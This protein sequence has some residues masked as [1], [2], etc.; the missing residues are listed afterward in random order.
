MELLNRIHLF[1]NKSSQK[2]RQ[3]IIILFGIVLFVNISVWVCGIFFSHIHPLLLGLIAI[4]YGLG[5]RHAVDADH[6]AAIDN[7]TRKLMLDGKRPVSVGLFFSLGHSTIVFILSILIAFSSIYIKHFLPSL[8]STGGVIGTSISSF[9]L[10][11]IGFVNLIAFLDILRIFKLVTKGGKYKEK[12]SEN[13]F[14]GGFLAKIFG[15]ALKTVTASWHMYFVGFLFGLGFDTASEVGF[16]SISAVSSTTGISAGEILLLPLAFTAGMVLIDTF[17]GILMLG[18]YG[19]AYIQ[20]VRKLYYNL[21]ITLVS[22]IIALFIGGV[23]AMQLF[24]TE[25]KFDN[26]F[27]RFINTIDFGKLGYIT[28]FIFIITWAVSLLVYKIRQ[29]DLIEA[30][31]AANLKTSRH[32]Q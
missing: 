32:P 13:Y 2:V 27:S 8:Q 22:V 14:Q 12:I 15:P 11:L 26:A 10:L 29:Y 7:T 16:L 5:L 6:I 17:D 24:S 19:W 18:A 23:E 28:I 9:F 30:G 21:N 1:W 31:G 4:A 20:P 25:F 3:R